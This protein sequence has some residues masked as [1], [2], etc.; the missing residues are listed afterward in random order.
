MIGK[1]YDG[2]FANGVAATGVEGLTTIVPVSA[3]SVLVLLLAHG[4][5]PQQHQ[6]PGR[7]C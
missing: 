5:H 2:T 4:R 6:L 1:S 7:P 3:I